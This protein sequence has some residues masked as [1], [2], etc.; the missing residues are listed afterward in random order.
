MLTNLNFLLAE[1]KGGTMWMPTAA[2]DSNQV[3]GLLFFILWVTGF[4]L[5]FNAGLMIFFA[6]RYRQTKKEGTAGGH[7]HNTAMELTWSVLPA[8]ILAIIFVW[9]FR[10]YLV[11]A[12]PPSNAVDVNVTAKKWGWDFAYEDGILA[13][14]EPIPGTEETAMAAL[15]VEADIPVRL[16]L[17]SVDV[18]HSLYIPAMRVKKDVV[19]GRVNQLWFTPLFDES[20]AEPYLLNTPDGDQVEVQRVEYELF[21]TEYCGQD[22]S[23]MI[24]K[25]YVYRAE[26]FDKWQVHN[27]IIPPDTSLVDLGKSIYSGKG[28]ASCHSIDGSDGTGPTWKDL[29]GQTDHGTSAGPV[30]V[31]FDYIYESIHQPAA[32]LAQKSDGTNYGNLMAPYP[33]ITPR[34]VVA[35]IEF[36]KS[37][38][39]T[40]TAD[41]SLTYGDLNTDGTLK[42]EDGEG[43]SGGDGEAEPA[44]GD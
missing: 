28:C 31:N 2:T 15:H 20:K 42:S 13:R 8:F 41:E 11:M 5:V 24:T 38:D 6:I 35:L 36:M 21:C 23:L 37:I 33:E 12:T 9:G 25:L 32:K 26:D 7:T 16:N 44:E 19:P 39:S 30:E 1:I 3:D 22:H 34:E 27:S 29:W 18:L 14:G 17:R 10:G 43:E 4:F 40:P